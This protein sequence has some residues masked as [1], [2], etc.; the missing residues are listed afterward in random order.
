MPVGSHCLRGITGVV[1]ARY[2][3]Y[4]ARVGRVGGR[5]CL[6]GRYIDFIGVAGYIVGRE[7]GRW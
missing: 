5:L 7:G 2:I 6:G 3:L 1:V 4:C